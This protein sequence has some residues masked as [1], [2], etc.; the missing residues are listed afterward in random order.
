MLWREKNH[1]AYRVRLGAKESFQLETEKDGNSEGR[2]G[3]D[4]HFSHWGRR[5]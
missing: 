2:S 4:G 5:E 3:R 1:Q